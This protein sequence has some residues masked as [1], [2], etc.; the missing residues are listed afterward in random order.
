MTPPDALLEVTYHQSDAASPRPPTVKSEL[1]ETW[2]RR[3]TALDEV[4]GNALPTCRL[5][6]AVEGEMA[7][8][9][10]SMVF[11]DVNN[12]YIF[13][14]FNYRVWNVTNHCVSN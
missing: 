7:T 5:G 3:Q 11:V 2:L 8:L 9:R 12:K 13:V 1:M 10:A 14:Q 6:R 4:S